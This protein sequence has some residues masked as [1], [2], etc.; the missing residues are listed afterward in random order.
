MELELFE[1]RPPRV[2]ALKLDFLETQAHDYIAQKLRSM[3]GI[4][5]VDVQYT[6]D[7][8][9][10]FVLNPH[11]DSPMILQS[12]WASNSWLVCTPG[13]REVG[14][15]VLYD[16]DFQRRYRPCEAEVTV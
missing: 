11:K 4:S 7:T 8:R 14:L 6:G 13:D 1:L 3:P 10:E 15:E 12:G 2:A 16:T 9:P 5:R